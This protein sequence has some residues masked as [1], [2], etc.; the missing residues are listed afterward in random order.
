MVITI[1]VRH[2][3]DCKWAGDEFHKGCNCRKHLRWSLRGKQYR[4]TAGT[5]SW[6]EAEETKKQLESQLTGIPLPSKPKA[7]LTVAEAVDKFMAAKRLDGLQPPTL[8]KLAKTTA[9]ILEFCNAAN[10]YAL[11]DVDLT[12]VTTW[13]WDRHFKTT[14]SFVVN[15]ERVKSFFK[16]F[17]NAGV[18]TR[19]PAASW[20]RFSGQTEQVSGFEPE[21]FEHILKIAKDPR[22]HAIISVMRFAGLAIIDAACLERSNVREDNGNYRICLVSRQKT[23]KRRTKQAIDNSI[24]ATV[25]RELLAVLNS[26]PRYVFWQG[27]EAKGTSAE[28]REAVKFWQKQIRALLDEAGYPQATSHKFRHTLAIEMIHHGATFEDVAAALGNTVATV[29]KYYSHEWA[30]NRQGHTDK[31]IQATW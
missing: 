17:H 30:K 11:D 16:Y 7:R 5:R 25:G 1:F 26:N 4:R 8:Q 10:I 22:L 12:H 31:S 9:R 21:Q 6:T 18:I 14:H 15:Q 27:G 20:K 3:Q 19:N 13:P 29:A 2:G 24:P 23:S 28:K